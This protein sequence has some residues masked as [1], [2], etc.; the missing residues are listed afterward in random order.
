MFLQRLAE[1]S[2]RIERPPSL[3]APM[4]IHWLIVIDENGKPLN[5]TSLIRDGDRKR[6]GEVR[7]APSLGNLRTSGIAPL[8]LADNGGYVLGKVAKK[9]KDK[10]VQ[11]CHKAFKELIRE[12]A[13]EIQLPEVEA[14]R[15]FYDEHFSELKIPDD[16]DPADNI[17]FRVNEC[18]VID[19]PE[20]REFWLKWAMCKYELLGAERCC[21]VCG[22]TKPVLRRLP[23][24]IKGVPRGQSS[25]TAGTALISANSDAFSSYGL[26]ETFVSPICFDCAERA[27]SALNA[28]L[29]DDRTHL[30]IGDV[31]YCFWT[32]EPCEF[33]VVNLLSQPT[34]EMVQRLLESVR[35]GQPAAIEA[36]D[37]YAA[38][39]SA[40]NA[41]VVVRSYWEST[42]PS[43]Q[44]NL[45]RWFEWQQLHRA[46]GSDQPLTVSR[47]AASLYHKPNAIK[48]GVVETLVRC[49]LTGAPLPEHL[50]FL[51]VKRNCAE[52]KVPY[53]R[54]KLI[55]AVL[56][57]RTVSSASEGRT[58]IETE[59]KEVLTMLNRN[60]ND[61]AYKCGRLL[62]VIEAIQS[63]AIGNPS[64]TVTDR[65][66]GSA[67]S[68]PASIFGTLLRLAQVH[69]NKLR[70]E[71]QAA[72]LERE[73][74]DAM[75]DQF[76][77]TLTLRQQGLFALGYFHQ[78]AEM[79]KP[80]QRT[81]TQHQQLMMEEGTES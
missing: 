74:H 47:L 17:T 40:N 72:F 22:Q 23:W 30:I 26:K 44:R 61:P 60:L 28:L 33:D 63:R 66:Y 54:A 25:G 38:A 18:W 53:E 80:R 13:D 14:I 21:L 1:Y 6:G 12:C 9:K 62:A 65:Y 77:A 79:Y 52:Q 64:Q 46:D 45:A 55:K 35:T 39:L 2:D 69:L 15:K 81:E 7:F 76:P 57:S 75:P 36:Q 5:M 32:R 31:V 34:P 50:L 58:G 41:R 8:L 67:S 70:K 16:F 24:A 11:D 48:P 42:L 51:A 27:V 37:F 29:Q 4:P 56:A 3:Y 19:L 43:I 49:A 10:R 73:L 68:T 59:P 71:N 20:V 78:R